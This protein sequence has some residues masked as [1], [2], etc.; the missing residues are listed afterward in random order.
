MLYYNIKLGIGT[1]RVGAV[2]DRIDHEAQTDHQIEPTMVS[3]FRIG[4]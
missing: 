3:Q 2:L 4:W 1:C